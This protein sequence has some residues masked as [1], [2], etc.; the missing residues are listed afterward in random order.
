MVDL[1]P[2]RQCHHDTLDILFF[3]HY[4]INKIL[5]YAFFLHCVDPHSDSKTLFFIS[6][7]LL[8]VLNS[9]ASYTLVKLQ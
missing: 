1:N 4:V 6:P 7:K 5:Q 9:Q 8:H 3:C 2:G